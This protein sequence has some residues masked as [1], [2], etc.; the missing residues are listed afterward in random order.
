M[1]SSGQLQVH[2]QPLCGDVGVRNKVIVMITC[3]YLMTFISKGSQSLALQLK[4]WFKSKTSIQ[5]CRNGNTKLRWNSCMKDYMMVHVSN[6][7][8]R[9]ENRPSNS[10]SCGDNALRLFVSCSM[11][12]IVRI[13][14][15]IFIIFN[16]GLRLG[17]VSVLKK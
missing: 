13:S 1:W 17:E 7:M 5:E 15:D 11:Y 6:T 3:L 14:S 2:C 10:T 12:I 4:R 8:W 16:L 9:I